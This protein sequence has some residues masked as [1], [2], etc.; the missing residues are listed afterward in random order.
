[1]LDFINRVIY[2]NL[3]N[4][5]DRRE[6][7][8]A[9]LGRVFTPDR[10]ERFPAILD[11]NGA[12]GCAKSHIAILEMA[13]ENKWNNVLIVEDDFTWQN[14]SAGLKNL[15]TYA[16]I[17]FDV[18]LLGGAF[19]QIMTDTHRIRT[20]QTTVGYLVNQHY[21]DVLIENFKAAAKGLAEGKPDQQFAIDQYWKKL[22]ARDTW[23]M[24]HPMVCLQRPSYSDICHQH[25]DYRP[26]F[27]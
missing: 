10:F 15:A 16:D 23:Y 9:E 3:D 6:E 12:L 24:V 14:M 17:Q 19:A 11:R 5:K 2:I 8:E 27:R 26:F 7:V 25:V 21:Y 20:A 13:K 4:R 18:L 1:M 22:Q